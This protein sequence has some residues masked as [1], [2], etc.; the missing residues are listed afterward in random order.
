MKKK[1]PRRLIRLINNFS[2]LLVLFLLNVSFAQNKFKAGDEVLLENLN[3][4]KGKR[5]ALITNKSAVLASGG[6]ITGVLIS[7]GINIQKIFTPEHGFSGNDIASATE[8]NI[9]IISLY[10]N[11]KTFTAEQ[12]N[13][14]DVLIFD[15]QD[16]G[17]RYYTYVSTLYL[18]MKSACDLNKKFILC[19]R[20]ALGNPDYVSGYML[21]EKFSS[22]VG[23]IPV[24]SIYGMTIG[25]L[26]NY[27]KNKIIEENGKDFDFEVMKMEG[28]TR[29][30]DY[31]NLYSNW[32]DL[33]PSI[34]SVESGRIY[35]ALVYLEGTNISEGRGTDMPFRVFGAPFCSGDEIVKKLE[36]YNLSGVKFSSV[37]YTP[38]QNNLSAAPKFNNEICRGVKIEI[39]NLKDFK[40]MEL[41]VAIL[42]TLKELYPEFKWN[43][44]NFID[45]L[46]GS[47][48][49]RTMIDAGK[50]YEEIIES[51]RE[52]VT[53][54]Q[55]VREKYLL[56]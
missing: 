50:S 40:P 21:D 9:K 26:G 3:L 27:L 48:K 2:I 11:A 23:L 46:A 31:K 30:A 14:I 49:L 16:L 53:S 5:I 56:Y 55:K 10:D 54:F 18:T 28:Y 6:H 1:N 37:E 33:S 13:D 38:Q 42:M 7:N 25:E 12:V 43:K 39:V 22:F 4:L 24:P 34:T 29:S 41:S 15:I 32:V 36:Q 35:P 45:K 19:D 52:D 44:G 51:Y 47:D 20:P 8:Q 17:V